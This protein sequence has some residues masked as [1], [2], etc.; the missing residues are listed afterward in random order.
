MCRKGNMRGVSD[1]ININFRGTHLRIETSDKHNFETGE[2]HL[3][4]IPL[5]ITF[6]I[7]IYEP[8]L[9]ILIN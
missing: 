8:N 4:S 5:T 7:P 3:Y 1:Y 9:Y 2:T 6:E